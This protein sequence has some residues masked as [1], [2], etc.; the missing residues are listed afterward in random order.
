MATKIIFVGDIHAAD[1]PPAGRVDGYRE[2]ILA[3]LR[4]IGSLTNDASAVVLL[5]DVFHQP[6]A[7][8]VSHSLVKALIDRFVDYACPIYAAVGNH[9]MGEEGIDSLH[10]Q[11][12]GVLE[13]SG[14]IQ[15]V[16]GTV[17]VGEGVWLDF[18]HYNARRDADPAYYATAVP[19]KYPLVL[20]AHGSLVPPGEARPYPTVSV[21]DIPHE[22]GTRPYSLIVSGHIHEDMGIT[23]L[24]GGGYFA[25]C[26]SIAR[27]SR[28][29]GN[30]TRRPRILSATWEDGDVTFD[31]YELESAL[32]AAEVFH[33]PDE[34]TDVEASDEIKR[35]AAA[36]SQGLAT[37]S[38]D[39]RE[40]VNSLECGADAKA[41]IIRLLTEAGAL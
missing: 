34:T 17:G 5:G 7:N 8:L 6:R 33:A 31:T 27:V 36:L 41:H 32:P 16:H 3:K 2:Q 29:H 14:A 11:P 23:A 35:F 18:R 4:E 40:L 24:S 37:E 19:N 38:V 13:A 30:L 15:I 1:R 20:V 9:D 12:I 21:A 39:I 22:E 10:R 25:N 28:T 26:G